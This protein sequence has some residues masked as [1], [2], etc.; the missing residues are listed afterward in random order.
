VAV[1]IILTPALCDAILKPN[2]DTG[3]ARWF[4]WFNR[5]F[6]TMTGGY[7]GTAGYLI[8]RPFRMLLLFALLLGGAYMLYTRLPTSFVPEEDQGVL[9]TQISLPP[10][11]NSAR[12]KAVIKLV[13]KYYLEN[14]K[15]AVQSVFTTL[16]FSFNGSG[17]NNAMAFV[18]L[19]DYSLRKDKNLS[20]AAIARRATGYFRKIRDAQ[21]FALAPPSIRGL[22]QSSGFTM[23]LEDS[24][25]RGRD[26]LNKAG[27]SLL[28]SAGENTLLSGLRTK[29]QPPES[30]MQIV[31]DQEK[32][33]ALGVSLAGANSL[34]TTAFSG[35]YVN[36]FIYNGEVKSVYVQGDAPY[37]MQPEDLNR[38]YVKNGDGGMVPFS[39]I[40][41][42]KWTE[43][44]QTL[45][46]FNG[47]P[48]IEIDGSGSQ[49]T[50]SGVAMDEM[51]KL[52][53]ALPG[54]FTLSW[55]ALSYQEQ[56]AGSQ[57]SL[58]YG[59]SV[60][61]VFLCLAALYESWSIPFAVI[62]AVPSG[63]FGALLGATLMAQSNDV[64]FKVGLL[65]TIGLTAKNAILI[66]EFARN[67]VEKGQMPVAAVLQ[68]ARLRLR[69]IVMTSLAFILG[70]APLAVA[71][72]AGSAAQNAIGVGVLG[73][74][75][76]A[77]LLGVLFVPLLFVTI[78]RLSGKG[79]SAAPQSET[80]AS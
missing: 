71:T 67:L 19:K 28:A 23:Y 72:G 39:A 33:G 68:A 52:V 54:G 70:V 31:V 24:G 41:S 8:R 49:G 65:T 22:G 64:Y 3:L 26:E 47:T 32:S 78:M 57:A 53:S 63:V 36:D 10:G 17:V 1:A 43:G 61:V 55:V 74:M 42:T 50:S 9:M 18:K 4:H 51:Q 11:A 79:K 38:W 13:E 16:G 6:E 29:M 35:T 66:V 12:T 46:R 15:A 77:T 30:Q 14:E 56:L 21:I 62:L 34:I 69:P 25:N 48:A 27:N 37:R 58:L 60:L 45:A 73:G 44:A 75:I 2:H 76:T 5:G 40:T 7:A 20:A 59:V 80:A